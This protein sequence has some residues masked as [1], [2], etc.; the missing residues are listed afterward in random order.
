MSAAK[1]L[2][3]FIGFTAVGGIFAENVT[4]GCMF[5]HNYELQRLQIEVPSKLW[6]IV[7]LKQTFGGFDDHYQFSQIKFI[8]QDKENS[9]AKVDILSG[10]YLKHFVSAKFESQRNKG[11]NFT[12]IIYGHLE[13][14]INRLSA[15]EEKD[16]YDCIHKHKVAGNNN[17][18]DYSKEL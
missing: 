16:L 9:G 14:K 3:V 7:E 4:V 17:Y 18:V 5:G 15:L 11:I 13:N 2:I 8:D 12:V 1:L 6:Q 10:G